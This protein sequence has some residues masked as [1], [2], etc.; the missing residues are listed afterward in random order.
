VT[1]PQHEL[2][3]AQAL[4]AEGL[5]DCEI[6]R[7]LNIPRVTIRDWRHGKVPDY[8]RSGG[9]ARDCPLCDRV[10]LDRSWYAYLLGMYLGDGCI[11]AMPR[12]VFNLR[13][14]LDIKYVNIIDECAEA[15]RRMRPQG[16]GRVGFV[17]PMGGLV[18]VYAMWKHWPCLFPQHGPG[19]KYKRKIALEPW[20]E[21]I[22]LQHPRPLLRGLIH[23]DGCRD[24]NVV[25]GKSY[26]RYS[27]SNNSEDIKK[28]FCNACDLIGIHWTRPN[29][30]VIAVSRRPDVATLD[31]FI[32][33]KT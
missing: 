22:A 20:Q 16:N 9:R 17:H 31:R 21:W 12:G 7:R 28:I 1:R 6:G 33:P 18:V 27:F 23:S 10:D 26:P 32:G 25:K 14:A 30:K 11:S 19:M 3:S 24:K 4:I 8:A 2:H 13:V 5:N 15:I 29:N